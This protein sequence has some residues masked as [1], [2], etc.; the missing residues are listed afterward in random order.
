MSQQIHPR[1]MSF[2]GV[3]ED[4][5]D[6]MKIGRVRV[7]IHGIHNADKTQI[8]TPDFKNASQIILDTLLNNTTITQNLSKGDYEWRIRAKNSN[9]TTGFSITNF[10]VN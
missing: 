10:T 7:R 3:V 2:Y 9:Y 6:P 4:R 1:M 8:A 5:H